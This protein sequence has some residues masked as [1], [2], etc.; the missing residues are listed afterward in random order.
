MDCA[1]I[2]QMLLLLHYSLFSVRKYFET[3]EY[4]LNVNYH[5][6]RYQGINKQIYS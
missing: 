4:K 3:I 5:W 2:L 6:N 1:K